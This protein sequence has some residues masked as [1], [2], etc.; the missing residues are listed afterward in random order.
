M[1]IELFI[2]SLKAFYEKLQTKKNWKNT[3]SYM[4]HPDSTVF[5]MAHGVHRREVEQETWV[6]TITFGCETVTE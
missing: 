3:S 5:S 2:F 1:E 6:R 4:Q